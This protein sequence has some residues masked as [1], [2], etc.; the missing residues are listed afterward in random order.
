MSGVL[1]A[2]LA[3]LL[4]LFLCPLGAREAHL[5]EQQVSSK[6]R[7][8]VVVLEHAFIKFQGVAR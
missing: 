2:A 8:L 5:P 7:G 6:L 4:G 1:Q 3:L